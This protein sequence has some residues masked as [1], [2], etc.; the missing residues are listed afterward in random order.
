VKRVFL[1]VLLLGGCAPQGTGPD[2]VCERDSYD[3]PAVK[4]MMVAQ[5]GNP[6]LELHQQD[7]MNNARQQAKRACLRRL[8]QLP[9]GG[10]GVEPMRR[11]NA[12]FQGVF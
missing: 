11:P 10:G 2:A 4:Q 6:A 12:L 8:G 3:D 1:V 5:A 9:A 7:A